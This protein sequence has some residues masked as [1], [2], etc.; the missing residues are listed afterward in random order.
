MKGIEAAIPPRARLRFNLA[1]GAEDRQAWGQ[2]Y[3]WDSHAPV[4]AAVE[5]EVS[6]NARRDTISAGCD[7]ESFV[8][9]WYAALV[10]VPL[11]KWT[12]RATCDCGRPL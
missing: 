7:L 6:R 5:S 12:R 10:F 1:A 4:V 11:Y 9:G 8:Y 2:P 3:S